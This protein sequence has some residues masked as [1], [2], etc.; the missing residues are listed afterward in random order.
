MMPRKRLPGIQWDFI[1]ANPEV[2]RFRGCGPEYGLFCKVFKAEME[3]LLQTIDPSLRETVG[4][5]QLQK[6]LEEIAPIALGR[7]VRTPEL[8]D[9]NGKT[10]QLF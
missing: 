5:K 10:V 3:N 6:S 7:E 2:S 4:Y 1:K 8:V 9:E